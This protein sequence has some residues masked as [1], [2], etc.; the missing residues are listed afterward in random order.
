MK[1]PRLPLGKRGAAGPAPSAG[2]S[3]TVDE[4]PQPVPDDALTLQDAAEPALSP[5]AQ[6]MLDAI[7]RVMAPQ[8]VFDTDTSVDEPEEADV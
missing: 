4:T 7:D 3:A 5:E 2:A 6:Q 8:S 1:F